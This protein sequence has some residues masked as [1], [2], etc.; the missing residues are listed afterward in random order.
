MTAT[1]LIKRFNMQ[2]HGFYYSRDSLSW[3]DVHKSVVPAMQG[4][5]F[6]PLDWYFIEDRPGA[7]KQS[8]GLAFWTRGAWISR[9]ECALVTYFQGTL[10]LRKF[11]SE[12][13]LDDELDDMKSAVE[14]S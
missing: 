11:D 5:N 12:E 10:L 4:G 14:R 3:E 8:F 2:D 6:Q 9:G 13:E 1:E 7:W